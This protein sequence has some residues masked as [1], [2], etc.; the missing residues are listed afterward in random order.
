MNNE[1]VIPQDATRFLEILDKDPW[2]SRLRLI[3]KPKSQIKCA[4]KGLFSKRILQV[5]VNERAGIYIVIN[6]GGDT[7][8]E[9]TDCRAL[10]LEHDDRS[11]EEQAICWKGLLPVPT[12]QVF[13]GGKSLHQ[14]WV[15]ENPRFRSVSINA[16]SLISLTC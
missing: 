4:K 9:I 10:F 13:T 16:I 11:I 2:E 3:P 15:F 14:Y 7:D 8:Q 5:W 12:M 6:D 1:Y